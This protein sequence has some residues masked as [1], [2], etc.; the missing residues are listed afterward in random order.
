MASSEFFMR[1]YFQFPFAP[2]SP[3]PRTGEGVFYNFPKSSSILS[4]GIDVGVAVSIFLDKSEF[5]V[6]N[7]IFTLSGA[8]PVSISILFRAPAG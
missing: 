1:R 2:S 5:Q 8:R 7:N 3:E 6:F 4:M